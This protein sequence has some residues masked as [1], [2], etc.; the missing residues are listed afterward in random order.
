[1]LILRW[2]DWNLNKNYFKKNTQHHLKLTNWARFC[3]FLKYFSL[4][5]LPSSGLALR[6]RLPGFLFCVFRLLFDGIAGRGEERG[7]VLV[8]GGVGVVVVGGEG[9]LEHWQGVSQGD[10]GSLPEHSHP[11]V[12][13]LDIAD[14]GGV[15]VARCVESLVAYWRF[16][17]FP[18]FLPSEADWK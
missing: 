11:T 16:R 10:A 2:P 13:L 9:G 4:H 12:A 17:S 18:Q 7:L 6:T 5:C 15:L 14:V 8:E 1:M 3:Y